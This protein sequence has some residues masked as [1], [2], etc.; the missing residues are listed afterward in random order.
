M[1]LEQMGHGP[2]TPAMLRGTVSRDLQA[3]QKNVREGTTV[4]FGKAN[5]PWN[6][7]QQ[8]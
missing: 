3:G 4:C 6:A 7:S 1:K 8:P 2:R 5:K